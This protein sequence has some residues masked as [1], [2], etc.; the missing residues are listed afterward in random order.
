M[1]KLQNCTKKQPALR[2]AVLTKNLHVV[3][4]RRE[5]PFSGSANNLKRESWP[6]SLFYYFFDL[7]MVLLFNVIEFLKKA[8]KLQF[9]L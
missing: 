2:T 1:K 4:S 9:Y 7:S 8:T 3:K 6:L 5:E